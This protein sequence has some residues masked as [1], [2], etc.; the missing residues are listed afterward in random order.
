M[1][2]KNKGK[3]ILSSVITLLP[4]VF[5]LLMHDKL[6]AIMDT[7]WGVN[8]AAD[9]S[10][11]RLTAVIAL[12]LILLALQW[13]CVL[14]TAADHKNREQSQTV[15]GMVIWIIPLVSLFTNGIMY[16]AAMGLTVHILMLMPI[17]MGLMFSIIGNYLPKCRH[18]HTI[19][20]KL[21]WTLKNEE[22]WNATHRFGGKVWVVAGVLILFTV[23]LPEAFMMIATLVLAILAGII[24]TA[25]SYRYY[26]RQL[27]DGTITKE[28]VTLTKKEKIIR[29]TT[30]IFVF[31]ITLALGIV[32]FTGTITVSYTSTT[33]TVGTTYWNDMTIEY[34]DID[35]IE[36]REKDSRGTRTNGFGSAKLLLGTF[37]NDEFGSY[38]RYSYTTCD[39]CVVLNIHGETLVISGENAEKTKAI[40]DEL[41][42][43]WSPYAGN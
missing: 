25:Y 30:L 12:P 37:E 29:F 28:S 23:F 6:P 24:P 9:S 5:G 19:G 14:V 3:L 11:N 16:T 17:S 36:L 21:K 20:I 8:G 32:M 42:E 13:L 22:N 10:L 7:H 1:I 41:F 27:Q 26:R 4:M 33:F 35:R 15:F 39:A 38:T 34:D 31:M 40:Y 18:N 43:R 2:Q